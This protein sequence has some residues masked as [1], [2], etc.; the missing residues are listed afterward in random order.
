[1]TLND[2]GFSSL[3]TMAA[4]LAVVAVVST[5]LVVA[6]LS[7]T[8]IWLQHTS[9]EALLCTAKGH[10]IFQCE[11]QMKKRLNI[12]GGFFKPTVNFKTERDRGQYQLHVK[13]KIGN[14]NFSTLHKLNERRLWTHN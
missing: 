14:W 13:Y 8:K 3:E 7:F 6:Y 10:S 2:R 11:S 5:L 9:H 1:M 12:L 4:L